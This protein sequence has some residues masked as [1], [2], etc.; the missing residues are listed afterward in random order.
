M[1]V[2]FPTRQVYM[3][4][5]QFRHSARAR[6][7]GLVQAIRAAAL[8]LPLAACGGAGGPTT[9]D[10][11]GSGPEVAR[12]VATPA[13]G[14]V[15][16]T[17]SGASLP[18]GSAVQLTAVDEAGQ[19]VPGI[20]WSSSDAAVAAVSADGLVTGAAPGTATVTAA[21]RS[22][23]AGAQITVR[24]PAP[25]PSGTAIAPGEDIQARVDA[26]A[27]G[28][29]FVLGAGVHR[30]QHVRPKD[31][32]V[33][34]GEPGAVLSGARVLEGW[35]R[36]GAVWTVGG[37]TQQGTAAGVCEDG[38]QA[39]RWPEDLFWDDVPLRRVASAGE[40]GPGSWYFDY[41]GDRVLVGSDPTGH[42]V[43]I[44]VIPHAFSGSAAGVV[45]R[46]VVIEKYATPAQQGALQGNATSGWT[47]EDS[48]IRLNHGIG[49]R[50]GDGMRVLRSR[51]HHNGQM[52][53]G[54]S[55]DAVLVE[56]NEIDHNN[57]LGF[58][59]AWEAGG[60]KFVRTDGLVLRG[61]VSHHNHGHGLWTDID[62]VNTLYEANRLEDNTRSGIFH[63]ISYRAVIRGNVARRNGGAGA[64]WVDGAG[65][66]V[67]SSRD[68]EIYENVVDGNL[69]GIAAVQS[70]RGAG[71][72]GAYELANLYVHHNDVGMTRGRSGVV[73]NAGSQSVFTSM[74]VRF[75]ANRYTLGASRPFAWKD[76]AHDPAGWK[77]FG[78]DET[79][80]FG[81]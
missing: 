9:P 75:E 34:A 22:R 12:I 49:L 23:T 50:T 28:T 53:I 7:G 52:G 36:S 66:L 2:G 24:A 51:I 10:P 68:V 65:I 31:G 25:P 8:L 81:G 76:A 70:A 72:H 33:F 46:G 38:G 40:V 14:G 15:S 42:R 59:P 61:N 43:E 39:C 48:E 57:T 56:G 11:A 47:V 73:Q 78:H 4:H 17:P 1:P 32:M 54:G 44:S 45:I 80:T 63:E 18:A 35:T 41:A 30:L 6:A 55:G 37:Q 26:A 19:A 71:A 69:N 20:R 58:D 60:S 5:I 13:Q 21:S 74:N 64:A 27:P 79:G 77:G 16:V 3:F 29:R 67:N 62:N